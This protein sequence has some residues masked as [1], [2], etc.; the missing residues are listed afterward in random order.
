MNNSDQDQTALAP[1]LAAP[2][3]GAERITAFDT[4]RGFALL[5]I[6]I[7]NIVAMAYPLSTLINPVMFAPISDMDMAFWGISDVLVEGTLRA[8]FAMMFGAGI[9]LISERLSA[10]LSGRRPTVS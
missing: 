2:V 5:G 7:I 9:V 8:I 3:A 1:G 4:L 6:L 10:R